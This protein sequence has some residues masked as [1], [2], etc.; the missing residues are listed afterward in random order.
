M[1]LFSLLLRTGSVLALLALLCS[2]VL[3]QT[4]GSVS[5]TVLDGATRA[6]LKGATA[7]LHDPGDSAVRRLGGLSDSAGVFRIE[8]VPV[9]RRLRL[10]V[11]YVG[12]ESA[13]V[14]NVLVA[15]ESSVQEVGEIVLTARRGG[16]E[17]SV[18][19][20]RPQVTVQAD[21]TVYG[22]EDNP[23]YTAT[24]VSELLGQI[25]S[26]SVDGD[27]KVS[28]R[29]EDNV[30]IMMNG[31]PLTMPAE[32]RNKFLQSLPSN[33]VKSIEVR[34]SPGAQ[35]NASYQGGIINI[36]TRRTV[37]DIF[38]GN[39]NAGIDSRVSLNGGGGLYYNSEGLNAS[40]GGSVYR[41]QGTGSSEFTRLNYNDTNERRDFG[42]GKTTS[43]SNSYYGY[44][45]VDYSITPSDLA[46]FSFN[47]NTWSSDYISSG[48]HAF[49]NTNNTVVG[50]FFDTSAPNGDVANSGGYNSASLLYRHT[51]S[52][53]HK[54][55]LD[56]SYNSDG[57][58]SDNR[59]GIAY[60]KAGGEFDSIRSSIR[61]TASERSGS[62]F[63]ASLDYENPISDTFTLS[64]G[65]RNERNRLDNGT[66]VDLL[67]RST[68]T[69]VPDLLRTNRYLSDNVIYALYG[70]VAWKPLATFSVQLGLRGERATVAAHNAEGASIVSRDY[71]N[72][73]PSGS[74]TWNF[75]ESQNLTASYR[76]S[77][78]LPDI[79]ALNPTRIR[80]TDFFE[81]SGNPDLDPEFTH[82]FQLGY[83]S[84]WGMGNMI[85][86]TPYYSTTVG[87]IERSQFLTNSVIYSS[88]ANF[89]GAW[90][91]GTEASIMLRPIEW[92]NLRLSGDVHRKVNR[93]GPILGDLYSVGVGYS[94]NGSASVDLNEDLTISTNLF[95]NTPALVGATQ[96]NTQIYWSFGV[97]QRLL[98]RKLTL[99]LRVNDPFRMQRWHNIYSS[100]DLYTES[101]NRWAS[102]F[103]G[104][105]VS[106]TFGTTPRMQEHRQERSETKGGGGTGG[107]AGGGGGQ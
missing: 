91:L 66:T 75:A 72:I 24:T 70:N 15:S 43:T 21:K 67:D 50:R 59:Y 18:T 7:T 97:R 46:S 88:T 100:S 22:V 36:V 84:F 94:A 82:L 64:F 17:L 40:V 13:S 90:S 51:F 37:S 45:Q 12:Y 76:R 25:P 79:D 38:G 107:G 10:E 2:P 95:L 74:L 52:G 78:A 63:I 61:R 105:N 68:G 102:Q 57:Y 39:L 62:T 19:A 4:T 83:T 49:S 106:Y 34:T 41:G 31:R 104:L 56:M 98:D 29:G 92:L 35:F 99:S 87:S 16:T 89:N 93:G 81:M 42:V 69:Y 80:Y 60:Y 48:E 30:T 8:G 5:G 73:F 6:P 32:Q 9:G 101:I 54:I 71:T 44:G 53:E 11:R 27:G 103:V 85:S 28:L 77:I 58:T 33:V 14:E 55:S 3:A 47:L 1:H 65:A 20:E 23:V 86:A 26:V 96:Q